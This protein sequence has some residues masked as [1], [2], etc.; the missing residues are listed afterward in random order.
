[1]RYSKM[2]EDNMIKHGYGQQGMIAEYLG[3]IFPTGNRCY[4]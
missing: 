4:E 1:M 3:R 2:N